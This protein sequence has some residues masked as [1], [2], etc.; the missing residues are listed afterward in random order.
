MREEQA[1]PQ[2][3]L[4]QSTDK[5][6]KAKKAPKVDKIAELEE[7]LANVTDCLLHLATYTG[8][9]ALV[10]KFGLKPYEYRAKELKRSA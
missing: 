3:E 9:Q 1:Q 10:K 2:E 6:S 5:K 7:K 4:S 8:N